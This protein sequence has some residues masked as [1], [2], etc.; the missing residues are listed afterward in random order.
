MIP[1]IQP[2]T[3]SQDSFNYYLQHAIETNHFANYGWA[4]K[5]LE[6]KAREILKIDDSKAVIATSSGTGA[7]AAIIQGIRRH[8]E[9]KKRRVCTQ[10]FT[11]TTN[12]L[13]PAE[14]PIAVS[15]THLTLPTK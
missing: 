12:S 10:D 3:F 1:Y 9:N 5:L 6:E 4:A 7:L 8:T 13:G 2:K 14:G 15:Y 11:F